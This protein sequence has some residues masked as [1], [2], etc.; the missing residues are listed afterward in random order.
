MLIKLILIILQIEF[1]SFINANDFFKF[2]DE[3]PLVK[4]I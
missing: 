1:V 3:E 2:A 4:S